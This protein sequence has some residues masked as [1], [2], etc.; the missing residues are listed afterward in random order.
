MDAVDRLYAP[1][2][3]AGIAH[4]DAQPSIDPRHLE[5]LVARLERS[6]FRLVQALLTVS[7]VLTG[8]ILLAGRVAPTI[9]DISVFGL[10]IFLGSCVWSAWLMLVARRHLREWE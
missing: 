4:A 9:W 2:P 7:G 8:A 10:F 1:P 3:P 5:R 6:Q